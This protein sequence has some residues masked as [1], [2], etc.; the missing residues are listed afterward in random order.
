MGAIIHLTNG[1]V[2]ATLDY[3][4]EK[5]INFKKKKEVVTLNK[6]ALVE[7]RPDQ[8]GGAHV[9]I[10]PLD[11]SHVIFGSTIVV[12]AED[13]KLITNLK[14]DMAKSIEN[15]FRKKEVGLEIPNDNIT[16]ANFGGSK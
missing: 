5:L 11:G 2:L 10:S 3:D 1:T 9:H 14:P 16:K 15:E 12:N 8:S 4:I 6:L 7:I 13:I